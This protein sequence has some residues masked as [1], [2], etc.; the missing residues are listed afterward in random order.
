MCQALPKIE[1][2]WSKWTLIFCDERVVP[3]D[4]E[5]STFKG[6]KENLCKAT[7]LTVEQ[8]VV[9][10]PDLHGINTISTF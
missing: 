1:T 2:E 3:F 10:N 7:P 9:I 8:F 4:N 5:D 6:Y